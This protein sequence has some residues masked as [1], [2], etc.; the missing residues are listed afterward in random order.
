MQKKVMHIIDMLYAMRQAIKKKKKKK[1]CHVQQH[2]FVDTFKTYFVIALNIMMFLLFNNNIKL[3]KFHII[4]GY[5]YIGCR[6]C[7]VTCLL[8]LIEDINIVP[9]Q[10][11]THVF[12]KFSEKNK[13]SI[14]K[15]KPL[16]NTFLIY[17]HCF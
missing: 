7:E 1:T 8:L 9:T 2:I 17:L 10:F 5:Y 3:I 12:D 6:A 13:N 11:L 15:R 4:H 14:K 16:K